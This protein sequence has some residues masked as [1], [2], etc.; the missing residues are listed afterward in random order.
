MCKRFA[1]NLDDESAFCVWVLCHG[2]G[3]EYFFV[4]PGLGVASARSRV[5]QYGA[6]A[7]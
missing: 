7:E 4:Y 1:E 3:G 5:Q 2:R 6:G